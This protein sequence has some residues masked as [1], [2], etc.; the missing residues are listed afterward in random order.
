MP[1]KKLK[2]LC[3]FHV[4]EEEA[5]GPRA[6]AQEVMLEAQVEVSGGAVAASLPSAH[7]FCHFL[8]IL[9]DPGA[10]GGCQECSR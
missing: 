5:E 6:P 3:T 1:L 8:P 9:K 4:E 2:V 7:Y 10:R